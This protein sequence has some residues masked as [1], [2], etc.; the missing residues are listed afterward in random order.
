MARSK[1]KNKQVEVDGIIFDSALE[2]QYYLHLK[3]LQEQGIVKSFEMQKNVFI[4]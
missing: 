1:Y 3:Q 2:S 4:A